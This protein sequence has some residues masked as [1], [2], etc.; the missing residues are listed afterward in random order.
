MTEVVTDPNPENLEAVN[1]TVLIGDAAAKPVSVAEAKPVEAAVSTET[2]VEYEPTGDPG[3]DMALQF[4]GKA[5]LGLSHPAMVAAVAG[6]FSILKA[7]LASKGTAGWEQYVALGEA[8]YARTTKDTEAKAAVGREAIYKE[9]GGKDAWADVQRWA[10]ENATPEEKAEINEL[11]NK[12]GLAARGAV[13]YLMGAY[14]TANNVEVNPRDPLA[15]SGRQGG[16]PSSETGPLSSKAYS[17]A[18]N[19]LNIKLRGRLDG[20]PEYAKLQARRAAHR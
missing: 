10:G 20:S 3:L 14:A 18:V 11:L 13:R 9:A 15:N 4:I 19:Q 6:D 8:A 2:A 12:G 16:A 5:G 1:A 7:T 17:D